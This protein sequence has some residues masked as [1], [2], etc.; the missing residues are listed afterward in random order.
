MG[1]LRAVR[2]APPGGC[3]RTHRLVPFPRTGD[4]RSDRTVTPLVRPS[5]P[6]R[7]ATWPTSCSPPPSP[8][9]SPCPP[10]PPPG[11]PPPSDEERTERKECD[12]TS[13]YQ[14]RP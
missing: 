7:Q 4:A 5:P 12:N 10:P 3:S 14:W 6:R 1:C 9:P 13:K 11:P 8:P 2:R